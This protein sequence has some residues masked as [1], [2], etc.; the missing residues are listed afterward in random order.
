MNAW[1]AAFEAGGFEAAQEAE[2]QELKKI[3]REKE[4]ADERNF[5]AFE[6]MVRQ[7]Q[8]VRRQ[9]EQ[10]EIEDGTFFPRPGGSEYNP[11]SGERIVDVP[12]DDSLRLAREARWGTGVAA[13]AEALIS[14]VSDD[15]SDLDS[16]PA[17]GVTTSGSDTDSIGVGDQLSSVGY[18]GNTASDTDSSS[19]CGLEDERDFAAHL[20]DVGAPPP[21]PSSNWT[22]INII[23]EE[24]VHA[25]DNSQGDVP[26]PLP[27]PFGGDNHL[28]PTPPAEPTAIKSTDLCELD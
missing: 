14:T 18:D 4:E 20:S 21:P 7:G 28:P 25:T 19:N 26:P 16:N 17:S 24:E 9:R 2:R 10:R 1:A 6:Q 22:S 3:K 27:D 15:T 23:E 11:F 13:G 12:E 8:A 5:R